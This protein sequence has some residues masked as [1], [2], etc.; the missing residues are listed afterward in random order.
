MLASLW[1]LWWIHLRSNRFVEDESKLLTTAKEVSTFVDPSG[2]CLVCIY[3]PL[4]DSFRLFSIESGERLKDNAEVTV[5][6]DDHSK[7]I[8]FGTFDGVQAIF[9]S[10]NTE[11]IIIIQSLQFSETKRIFTLASD[12]HI[13]IVPDELGEA[14]S[15][16]GGGPLIFLNFEN[17]SCLPRKTII[18]CSWVSV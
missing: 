12:K 17:K 9:F 5:L 11:R 14:T 3:W 18:L 4:L 8:A 6:M 10:M 15:L 2:N 1:C 16:L 13:W 7:N